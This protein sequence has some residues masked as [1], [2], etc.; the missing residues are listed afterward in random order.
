MRALLRPPLLSPLFCSYEHHHHYYY[1]IQSICVAMVIFTGLRSRGYLSPPVFMPPAT[2]ETFCF[3]PC[4]CLCVR[5]V[6]SFGVL[7]CGKP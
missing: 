4:V 2:L 1:G 6:N 5:T 7:L 3:L